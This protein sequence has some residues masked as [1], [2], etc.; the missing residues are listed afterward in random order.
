MG[1][2]LSHLQY[3]CNNLEQ[4]LRFMDAS[5]HG[6]WVTEI[7]ICIS[8]LSISVRYRN[9][10]LFQN[11]DLRLA[12]CEGFEAMVIDGEED[13]LLYRVMGSLDAGEKIVQDFADQAIRLGMT[14]YY[15]ACVAPYVHNKIFTYCNKEFNIE[16][17]ILK[18]FSFES[19][20]S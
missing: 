8:A 17:K 9:P 12:R 5:V 16:E 3:N 11:E 19:K 4:A 6:D 10:S 18:N 1:A 2:I 20:Q 15:I 14:A 13:D 7:F